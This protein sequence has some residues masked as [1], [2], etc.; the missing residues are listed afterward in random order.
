M[1]TMLK[2]LRF[3]LILQIVLLN[4]IVLA[5]STSA[6]LLIAK[7]SERAQVYAQMQ[8]IAQ[9]YAN[10]FDAPLSPIQTSVFPWATFANIRLSHF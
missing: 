7:N 10:Q 2:S 6:T 8:A 5:V 4:L 3:K 9:R 1:T